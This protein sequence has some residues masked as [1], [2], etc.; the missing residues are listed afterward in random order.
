MTWRCGPAVYGYGVV[1]GVDV[2]LCAL[3]NRVQERDGNRIPTQKALRQTPVD[4]IWYKGVLFSRLFQAQ[5]HTSRST[6]V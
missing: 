5:S 3:Y 1:T 6:I 4:G 2:G